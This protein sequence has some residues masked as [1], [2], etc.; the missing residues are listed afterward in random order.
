MKKITFKIGVKTYEKYIK[1]EKKIST[2]KLLK[3][4]SYRII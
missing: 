1:N 3:A 2:N 4:R